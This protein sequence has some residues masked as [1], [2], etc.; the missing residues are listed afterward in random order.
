M[1][2]H[3]VIVSEQKAG[4]R[5]SYFLAEC[6]VFSWIVTPS[7]A[8]K[9][10]GSVFVNGEAPEGSRGAQRL[11]AGDRVRVI[12]FQ[13]SENLLPSSSSSLSPLSKA[14]SEKNMDLVGIRVL[15]EHP[16]FLVVFKPAGLKLRGATVAVGSAVARGAQANDTQNLEC[17]LRCAKDCWCA[18]AYGYVLSRAASGLVLIV[19]SPDLDR[20]LIQ[21]SHWPIESQFLCSSL[22]IEYPR[23]HEEENEEGDE[24]IGKEENGESSDEEDTMCRR[25]THCPACTLVTEGTNSD[26]DSNR[27]KV[28][29]CAVIRALVWGRTPRYGRFVMTSDSTPTTFASVGAEAT[30]TRPETEQRPPVLAWLRRVGASRCNRTKWLSTIELH[31]PESRCVRGQ[32]DA[33]HL[34]RRHGWPCVND[35]SAGKSARAQTSGKRAFKDK[36]ML[37]RIAINTSLPVEGEGHETT[38]KHRIPEPFAFSAIRQSERHYF[39]QKARKRR[40]QE[41]CGLGNARSITDNESRNQGECDS[42]GVVFAGL[43]LPYLNAYVMRPR[44]A[45]KT[46]VEA[47]F[48]LVVHWSKIH[49]QQFQTPPQEK[50]AKSPPPL[51]IRI[52]DLGTGSGCLL[53]SLV[54]KI[55]NWASQNVENP[56]SSCSPRAL[57]FGV[58]IDVDVEA[59]KVA[60][61]N[62]DY[63]CHKNY[64][65]LDQQQGFDKMMDGLPLREGIALS[66]GEFRTFGNKTLWAVGTNACGYSVKWRHGEDK[67]KRMDTT[68]DACF[69]IVLCNPP[70]LSCKAYKQ[71]DA[72]D[73]EAEPF[74]A[75]CATEKTM[76]R[77]GKDKNDNDDN[78]DDGLQAYRQLSQNPFLR[79]AFSSEAPASS[80]TQLL[81]PGGVLLTEIPHGSAQAVVECFDVPRNEVGLLRDS[82]GLERCLI[83][84][85]SFN[86]IGTKET[87]TARIL[88]NAE[89]VPCESA[90]RSSKK[91]R[92]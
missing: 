91:R 36:I 62:A 85:S 75:L 27:K 53:L 13:A 61:K 34:L 46:L 12:P 56:T 79:S 88:L 71:L 4:I 18:V 57:A 66:R 63:L 84:Q 22:E 23:C 40:L 65:G 51:P 26:T 10:L 45:S 9:C 24:G 31:Y 69:D 76:D 6:G 70:Y 15:Q 38:V 37:A 11:Q 82:K 39:R 90:S 74:I 21:R 17:F 78:D 86:E 33:A 47:A 64:R 44:Q 7:Q 83:F 54:N 60:A 50:L 92:R 41:D 42:R 2:S 68:L 28:G 1:T 8:K 59:L 16:R 25:V 30:C 29:G 87:E 43:R 72:A 58:G 20:T 5:L 73:R 14:T 49:Q 19:K 55:W 48:A 67:N 77:N 81:R 32:G 3:E 35:P 52:L 80:A 89:M